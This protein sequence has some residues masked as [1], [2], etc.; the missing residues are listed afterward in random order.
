MIKIANLASSRCVTKK[1]SYR[2]AEW[3]TANQYRVVDCFTEA[4]Q[5]YIPC[6]SHK[7]EWLGVKMQWD[8][9]LLLLIYYFF[10]IVHYLLS[11]LSSWPLIVN[12]KNSL[13]WNPMHS[14]SYLMPLLLYL[15]E[16]E[17][18]LELDDISM[19]NWIRQVELV[20]AI[21]DKLRSSADLTN[22]ESS[23]FNIHHHHLH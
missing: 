15:L 16:A 18:P 7:K 20:F 1:E 2:E 6:S 11:I 8:I 13:C 19:L 10:I 4:K 9:M 21:T 3:I 12:N 14:L 17:V 22:P 23:H 5:W